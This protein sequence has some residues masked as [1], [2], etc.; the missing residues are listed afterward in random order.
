MLSPEVIKRAEDF[1]ARFAY[2]KNY[3]MAYDLDGS[4]NSLETLNLLFREVSKQKK[5]GLKTSSFLKDIS[6][7]L[8]FI[9]AG[10]WDEFDSFITLE[11]DSNGI[12]IS[13][14]SGEG[15]QIILIEQD[16]ENILSGKYPAILIKPEALA[17]IKSR[18]VWERDNIIKLYSFG[19]F[20]ALSPF[21]KG[22]WQDKESDKSDL[23]SYNKKARKTLAIS[24]SQNY[25]KI[26][27]EEKLGQVAELYLDKLFW[28]P[29]R[30][31]EK[32]FAEGAITSLLNFF[33]DFDITNKQKLPLLRN[34]ITLEDEAA[35]SAAKLLYVLSLEKIPE[36]ADI[37]LFSAH[38][39]YTPLLRSSHCF[40]KE[41]L[42]QDPEWL[43]AK[44]G[45]AAMFE[46]ESERAL[47]FLPNLKVSSNRVL[48][49]KN[50]ENNFFRVL[51]EQNSLEI[52][53][54]GLSFY[55]KE[56]LSL[57]DDALENEESL[58]MSITEKLYY[59]LGK[60]IE[61]DPGDIELRLQKAYLLY[62]DEKIEELDEYLRMLLTEPKAESDPRIFHLRGLTAEKKRDFSKYYSNLKT[63][64][65]LKSSDNYISSEITFAY[66][67][68]LYKKHELKEA[69]KIARKIESSSHSYHYFETDLIMGHILLKL[70]REDELNE[71]MSRIFEIAPFNPNV[72]AYAFTKTC[73]PL[74]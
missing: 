32:F 4:W 55:S 35:S 27:P 8:G 48:T 33:K 31:N 17:E 34:L 38:K 39:K 16:L 61:N 15:E 14:K 13:L 12:S 30:V 74:I 65:S 1:A 68:S 26:F 72:F 24:S 66:L 11:D 40:L 50:Y 69:L 58:K 28:P 73:R 9:A 21:G 64:Y 25:Q 44:E 36:K 23:V 43:T 51:F 47:G 6:A 5:A 37:Y 71:V 41:K 29:T 54:Q 49:R 70:N 20:S 46:F 62:E 19:L 10:Y 2:L 53:F 63:A 56:N 59:E 22:L 18:P 3:S 57:K 67:N 52:Y 45:P 60:L 42:T 7:Y